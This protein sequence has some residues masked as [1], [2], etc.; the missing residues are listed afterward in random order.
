MQNRAALRKKVEGITVSNVA[1][2]EPFCALTK[3]ATLVNASSKDFLI[4]IH[5]KDLIPKYFRNN[6]TLQGIE[7]NCLVLTIE[8][9][10]LTVS[11]YVKRTAMV[12]KGIFEVAVDYSSQDSDIFRECLFTLLPGK[13]EFDN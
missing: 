11:G 4:V 7:G 10:D 12:G 5:R 6:L 1:I 13:G 2:L 8:Q 9:M 3:H